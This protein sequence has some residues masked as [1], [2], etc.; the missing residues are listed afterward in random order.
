MAGSRAGIVGK[1]VGGILGVFV[2]LLVELI[3]T[4]L[5]YSYLNLSHPETFGWLVRQS[6]VVLD[7]LAGQIETWFKGWSNA[8]YATVFGELGPK[9]ILLLLM[10]LVVAAVI[11][12]GVWVVQ[13][14]A[15]KWD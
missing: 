14:L 4:M 2:L 15:G 7:I 8:A 1:A 5:L 10:G 6:R 3:A 9:S 12:W 11:R 13:G